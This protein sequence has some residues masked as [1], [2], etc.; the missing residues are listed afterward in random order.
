MWVVSYNSYPGV[1][2]TGL[3][4]LGGKEGNDI[5]LKAAQKAPNGMAGFSRLTFTNIS[6]K[7]FEWR[8]EWVN[9][10]GSIVYPFWLIWC[11][12]RR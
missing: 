11:E 5:V 7:G 2:T 8:G 1:T 10:T 9:E 6:E 3:T 4:W 12:K